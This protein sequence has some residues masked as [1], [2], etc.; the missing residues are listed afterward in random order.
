MEEK[1]DDQIKIQFQ[2]LFHPAFE[3]IKQKFDVCRR[4]NVQI[5][6]GGDCL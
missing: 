6:Q 5:N 3:S 2:T 4:M 1:K